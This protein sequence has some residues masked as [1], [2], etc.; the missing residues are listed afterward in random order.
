MVRRRGMLSFTAV[1][2]PALAAL[3]VVSGCTGS[4]SRGAQGPEPASAE[5]VTGLQPVTGLYRYVRTCFTA[6]TTDPVWILNGT[7]TTGAFN[8]LDEDPVCFY[9]DNTSALMEATLQFPQNSRLMYVEAENY[10]IGEPTVLVCADELYTSGTACGASGSFAGKRVSYESYAEDQ[11]RS[12]T[13]A[14][15]RLTITRRGDT[16]WKEFA[17]SLSDG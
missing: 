4:E 12:V 7:N 5:A 11:T 10:L 17:I 2:V 16:D 3:L 14:G 15:I 13:H 9:G 1:V 8:V 6:D